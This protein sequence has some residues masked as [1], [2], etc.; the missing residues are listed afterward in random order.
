MFEFGDLFAGGAF[1]AGVGLGR[2]LAADVLGHGHGESETVVAW[3][4]GKELCMTD[5]PIVNLAQ[6][7][8]LEFLRYYD[9]LELHG[10][11]I[12]RLV[13]MFD[14]G[15]PT[16]AVGVFVFLYGQENVLNGIHKAN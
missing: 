16:L 12:F 8:V 14:F 15:K 7:P 4:A 2:V 9:I 5:S 1:A 10:V 13:L 6:Q 11:F 3:L